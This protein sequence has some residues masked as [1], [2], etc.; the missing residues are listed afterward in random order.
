MTNSE[1]HSEE[2]ER[3][4]EKQES[5]QKNSIR[6]QKLLSI[7]SKIGEHDLMTGVKKMVKLLDKQYEVK[8]IIA[9]D[10]DNASHTSVS[11]FCFHKVGS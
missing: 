3:R 10:G 5:R 4:K 6:G 1:Y 11:T 7:S 9:G 8:I 2:L